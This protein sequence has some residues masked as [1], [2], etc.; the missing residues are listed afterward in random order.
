[1]IRQN[2]L[3]TSGEGGENLFEIIGTSDDSTA[4]VKQAVD[5]WYNS[6]DK[7]DW[8][9]PSATSFSQVV[10]KSTTDLGIGIAKSGRRAVVV[11]KY[12]PAGNIYLAGG[13]DPGKY[14]KDNVFPVQNSDW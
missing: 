13:G 10:W 12:S 7:Y 4:I 14:F 6:I 5:L 9:K 2:A 8:K 1:L 11:G 3:Q